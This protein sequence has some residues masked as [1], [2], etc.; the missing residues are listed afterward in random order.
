ML[1]FDDTTPAI[2]DAT[3]KDTFVSSH[4]R[5]LFAG[6]DVSSAPSV[7][8]RAKSQL[9]NVSETE[10]EVR[11]AIQKALQDETCDHIT[12]KYLAR[13]G[14]DLAEFRTNGFQEFGPVQ[15]GKLFKT[16]Q[17]FSLS[18]EF[19]V[20]GFDD[21][22]PHIFSIQD[23][24]VIRH[25]LEGRGVIGSGYYIAMGAFAGRTLYELETA[26]LVYRLCAAKFAAETARGVGKK[27]TVLV[28]ES[29]GQQFF[30][31]VQDIGKLR[32]IW[33]KEERDAPVPKAAVELG[34]EIIERRRKATRNF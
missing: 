30:W 24:G 6:D 12:A 18:L 31:L 4:W 34:E 29:D 17:K 3:L 1:S 25:D 27:T 33:E 13:W 11:S 21:D 9:T 19:L 2:E 28:L 7:I 26:E 15:F 5:A 23:S 16:I 20:Y 22:G 10:D 8:N 14:I 32:L